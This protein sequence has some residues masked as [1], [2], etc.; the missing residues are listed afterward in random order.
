MRNCCNSKHSKYIKDTKYL[1]SSYSE[2]K[3]LSPFLD[4]DVQQMCPGFRFPDSCYCDFIP[5]LYL[6]IAKKVL[7]MLKTYTFLELFF[8]TKQCSLHVI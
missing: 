5:V 1:T 4:L 8:F 7:G 3:K 6:G 2:E